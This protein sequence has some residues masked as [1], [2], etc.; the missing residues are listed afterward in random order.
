MLMCVNPYTHTTVS[1]S[2]ELQTVQLSHG[3]CFNPRLNI[4]RWMPSP[5]APGLN[6]N[7]RN[8]LL[9]LK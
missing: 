1:G 7:Y 2:R 9:I 5:E 6:V 4:F 3:I 8:L